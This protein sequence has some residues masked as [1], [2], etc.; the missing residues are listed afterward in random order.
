MPEAMTGAMTGGDPRRGARATVRWAVFGAGPVARK[1]V[2]GLRQAPGAAATLVASRD[3]ANAEAFARDLGLAAADSYEAAARSDA[4]DAV[5]IATPPA[6]HRALALECLAAGKP[7]LVEKPF[8]ATA[9]D[10]EAIAEAAR[11]AGVFCMEAM[12]TRFLPLVVHLKRLVAEGAIG[13]PRSFSGSFG[14][15]TPP[16]PGSS[17]FDPAQG[18]GALLHRGIYPLSLACHLLGP[19]SAL[20]SLARIGPTGV[21]EDSVLVLRHANGALSSVQASLSS[22]MPTDCVI[23]GTEGMIEVAA[24]IF[25]PY[26]LTLATVPPRGRAGP[27]HSRGNIRAEALKEGHLLQSAQQRLSG[28][29]GLIRGRRTRRVLRPYA[30]NGYHYQAEE[31][32][33]CVREGRTESAVMPLDASLALVRLMDRARAAWGAEPAGG[34]A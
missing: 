11:S 22:T 15:A 8:A 27:G 28:V 4:V 20:Q 17:L 16:E 5:Y 1:F 23:A 21:D 7:V 32:M 19:A 9:E 2:L 3:R 29:V 10:A 12:W 30:G 6:S 14:A 13:A 24:P 34:Q 26:R 33:R 31:L 25:R 18:G